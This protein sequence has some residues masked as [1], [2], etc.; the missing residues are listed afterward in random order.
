MGRRVGQWVDEW[1]GEQMG[2]RVN[3]WVDRYGDVCMFKKEV[4]SRDN[5]DLLNSGD[6]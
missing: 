3:G 2:G 1:V 4:I 6:C 5:W